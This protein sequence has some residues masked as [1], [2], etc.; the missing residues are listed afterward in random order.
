MTLFILLGCGETINEFDSLSP[1]EQANLRKR[2][3]QQC[4]SDNREDFNSFK[5]QSADEFSDLVRGDYYLHQVKVGSTVLRTVKVQVWKKTVGN[6]YFILTTTTAES[7]TPSYQFLKITS[8]VNA[9]MIERAA[10]A[11]CTSGL[12]TDTEKITAS[13]NSSNITYTR[14]TTV[15]I[16][17]ERKTVTTKTTTASY[18][19]LAFF[20]NYNYSQT[21]KTLTLDDETTDVADIS[22][23]GTITVQTPIDLAYATYTGYS[24]ASFCVPF[25][26]GTPNDYTFPYTLTCGTGVDAK[27]DPTELVL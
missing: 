22:T 10:T 18:Q 26:A 24:G 19:Y 7:S 12:K 9:E 16:E 23:T 5:S 4:L 2:G 14:E 3:Q 1:G 21:V 15:P 25:V 17:G 13:S 27:F 20:A 11:R 8:A 6:L